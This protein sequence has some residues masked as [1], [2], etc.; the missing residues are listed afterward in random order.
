[1]CRRKISA[2]RARV[3]SHARVNVEEQLFLGDR[4]RVTGRTAG[5]ERIQFE[6]SYTARIRKGDAVPIRFDLANVH[7]IGPSAASA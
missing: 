7:L 2:S 4:I 3:P 1:M 6:A 5:G